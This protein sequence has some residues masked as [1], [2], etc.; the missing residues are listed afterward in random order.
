MKLPSTIPALLFSIFLAINFIPIRTLPKLAFDRPQV[1]QANQPPD[2]IQQDCSVE[3][4]K[5]QSVISEQNQQLDFFKS[6]VSSLSKEAV[7]APFG[8]F[9]LIKQGS[10]CLA[11]RIVEHTQPQI[12][13]SDK[14]K[15]RDYKGA[16]YEWYL[17]PD[18]SMDFSKDNVLKGNNE[19]AET[20]NY[21]FGKIEAGSFKLRW[22]LSDWIYFPE[23]EKSE[24][25][26]ALTEWVRVED[27]NPRDEILRWITKQKLTKTN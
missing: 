15:F 12:T 16:K 9:L 18:G 27:I 8:R 4:K 13:I 6:L 14:G 5:L 24:T 26:M 25:E 2:E 19:L 3:I 10:Q 23:D 1:S 21:A 22:S 20:E 11:L 17:Q 7:K